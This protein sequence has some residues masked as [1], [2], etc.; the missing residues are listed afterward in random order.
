MIFKEKE[1]YN[2]PVVRKVVEGRNEFFVVENDGVEYKIKLYDFQK[3]RPVPETLLCHTVALQP[4]GAILTQDYSMFLSEFYQVGGTYP[5]HVTSVHT[6]NNPG[7]YKV[8]DRNGF[9]FRLQEYGNARLREHEDILCRVVKLDGYKL[10]LKLV[11]HKEDSALPFMT[12]RQL[13]EAIDSP[14]L[15]TVADSVMRKEVSMEFVADSYE[16]KRG[17][18]VLRFMKTVDKY[19]NPADI[20]P[21][22]RRRLLRALI[23]LSLYL[24]EGSAYLKNLDDNRRRRQRDRLE[25]YVRKYDTLLKAIDVVESGKDEEVIADIL[26]KMKNSGYLFNP[27]EKLALMISIFSLRRE[28]VEKYMT[29]LLDIIAEGN[30]SNWMQEPF[31]SAFLR[32]LDFYVELVKEKAGR[33]SYDDLEGRQLLRKM[34][35]ALAIRGLMGGGSYDSGDSAKIER[36]ALFRYLT[37]ENIHIGDKLL[38]KAFLT[39][40]DSIEAYTEYEWSDIN[41]LRQLSFKL[42]SEALGSIR[43]AITS[44]A[45]EGQTAALRLLGNNI[46]VWPLSQSSN[47]VPLLPPTMLPWHNIQI[48]SQHKVQPVIAEEHRLDRLRTFWHDIESALFLPSGLAPATNTKTKYLA[49]R[50]DVVDIV[51]DAPVD[52]GLT[53]ACHIEDPELEGRGT[54]RVSEMCKYMN[55][56]QALETFRNPEGKPYLLKAEVTGVR[57][58]KTMEFSFTVPTKEYLE[59]TLD[60]QQPLDCISLSSVPAY[61]DRDGRVRK[62]YIGFSSDGD[63][64]VCLFEGS[65]PRLMNGEV[66][67][68]NFEYVSEPPYSQAVCLYAGRADDARPFT[69]QFAFEAFIKNYSDGNV[70]EMQEESAEEEEDIQ[71]LPMDIESLYELIRI[72]D[73]VATLE[74]NHV[75]MFNYLSFCRILAMLASDNILAEYYSRRANFLRSLETFVESGVINLDDLK[76]DEEGY[77]DYPLIKMRARQMRVLSYFDRPDKND[78]LW[79]IIHNDNVES[80]VALAKLALLNNMSMEFKLSAEVRERVNREMSE[81]M[82]IEVKLPELVHFGEEGQE[83]EFKVSYFHDQKNHYNPDG[84]SDHIMERICGMLNSAT[85]GT[86]YIG[87]NDFGF[88]SG[89]DEDMKSLF[90]RGLATRDKYDNKVRNDIRKKLGS[91]ANDRIT[92]EWI[93]AG[94]KDVY[95]IHVPAC[96]TPISFNKSFWIRQGTS[97]YP[98]DYDAYNKIIAERKSSSKAAAAAAAAAATKSEPTQ[99]TQAPE[100]AQPVQAMQPG[101]PIPAAEAE[102]L[103]VSPAEVKAEYLADFQPATV[104]ADAT[105]HS[106]ESTLHFNGLVRK[107]SRDDWSDDFV[108]P[109]FYINFLDNGTFDITED[110]NWETE[111]FLAINDS[112]LDKFVTLVYADG[113]A[114]AVPVSD[115]AVKNRDNRYA[116][117]VDTPLIFASVGAP[118]DF[119]AIFYRVGDKILGRIELISDLF[120]GSM[121][122]APQPIANADFDA[123]IHCDIVPDAVAAKMKPLRN[124]TKTKVGNGL[125]AII[126][127]QLNALGIHLNNE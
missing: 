20:K 89:L 50:G 40:T 81:L 21:R 75:R 92:T 19:L 61:R 30:H 13:A 124:L 118:S 44:Q 120:H 4:D 107:N 69:K 112:E 82:K 11:D 80:T 60:Y 24:L 116:R 72:I 125:N 117:F 39:I 55:A 83:T 76:L 56:P 5:F 14:E 126:S 86:L 78:N 29:Q 96:N 8:R 119:L 87:V 7:Y 121:T 70:L 42:S 73:R 110:V 17:E 104:A 32:Q 63:P 94:G 6:L 25:G 90:F 114:I 47:L 77:M 52:N 106:G 48:Y 84:Q 95:A 37:F 26:A 98:H 68:A 74:S 91:I 23:D 18:W 58:D 49:E 62:A 100:P 108:P 93:E 3:S 1:S 36:A 46:S 64:I 31:R 127:R 54:I 34:I 113:S 33:S 53:F 27:G 102:S 38:E 57:R 16:A 101:Q 99:P 122:D 41:N 85:G 28:I 2:L 109:A 15:S 10:R 115:F 103:N 66:F 12:T 22:H 123:I 88:A 97:T 67:H 45:Y 79:E 111:R 105:Y 71:L 59:E 43:K 51:I 35:S 9:S 65:D